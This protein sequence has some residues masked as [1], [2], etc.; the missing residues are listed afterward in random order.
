M[1]ERKI[2]WVAWLFAIVALTLGLSMAVWADDEWDF[3]TEYWFLRGYNGPGGD[4]VVPDQIEGCAVVSITH[5]VLCDS[6][7]ITSLKLPGT[8]E[9]LEEGTGSYNAEMTSVELPESLMVIGPNCFMQDPKL[10]EITIPAQVCVLETYSLSFDVSLSK[11]TFEGECPVMGPYVLY[12]LA[13]DCVIYVPDD[14]Y[15]AYMQEFEKYEVE[16]EVKP[17]GQNA[18]PRTPVYDDENL[19][20]DEDGTITEYNGYNT[21]L[22]IPE[23]LDGIKVKALGPEVFSFHYYL[24]YVSLPEG[25]E[26]IGESAFDNAFYL[27]YVKLPSSVRT[28]GDHAFWNSYHGSEIEWPESLET[29]GDEAFYASRLT[30]EL[31]LPEGV[32][33]IGEKAFQQTMWIS[34]A[35]L[36]STVEYIGA[37]AFYDSSIDY[38]S[39]ASEQLPDIDSTAFESCDSLRDIDINTHGTK[40]EMLALQADVDALGLECRVWRNQ[41]PDVEYAEGSKYTMN[42]DGSATAVMVEYTGDQANIRPYDSYTQDDATYYPVTG[43]A[44]Q[45]LK[46]NQ[47]VTYFAVCYNDQLTS[48]GAEAFADSVIEKVDLFDS[49]TTIGEGAFRNCTG[50]TELTLPASITNIGADA[51]EGCTNLEKVNIQCEMSALPEGAFSGLT[52]LKEVAIGKGDIPAR[53]FENTA[54]TSI[55]LSGAAVIGERAFAGCT[56]ITEVTLTDDVIAIGS[57]A[58]DGISVPSFIIPAGIAADTSTIPTVDI[59]NVRISDAATDD[60]VAAWN[61]VLAYPWYDGLCR[62][63][64]ESSFIHMPNEAT[65][66]ENFEIDPET[67]MLKTYKGTAVDVVIPTSISGVTVTGISYNCFES[68]R[69]YTDTGMDTNQTD[70]VHLR[71]IVIPETVTTIEDSVFNNC[72]Q[73]EVAIL[74]SPLETSGRGVFMNCTS[75]KQVVFVNP[76]KQLDNYLFDSCKSLESVWYRGTLDRIGE[77]CFN[78]SGIKEFIADAKWI[79]N[80]AFVHCPSLETL[81]VR[82]S[83][84]NLVMSCVG[85]CQNIKTICLEMTSTEGMDASNGSTGVMDTGTVL[86]IPAETSDEEAANFFRKWSNF[87]LGPIVSEENV[88]RE[89]CSVPDTPNMPDLD[90]LLR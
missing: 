67:G 79:D 88:H 14:Q 58:W 63:S 62:V 44:D 11:V 27:R 29:I 23:Q 87:N 39:I 57:G 86:I 26:A 84:E 53:C 64:E 42:P 69:D 12:A 48:I 90:G 2:T 22:D 3:D 56:G 52:N 18:V 47:T 21:R 4:V 37:G 70:W 65:A 55:D 60:A 19:V 5:N 13:D 31:H 80:S 40:E 9:S 73:L 78:H 81:H 20:I 51:F 66:E 82:A 50:L 6:E 32:R 10:K 76:I 38:V 28:I 36:P 83:C 8:L 25:L 24:G 46:G 74:Y 33:S 77:S 17:S 41:N 1:K 7:T 35:Y 89:T 45:A 34:A 54:I 68:C 49:V 43:I 15:D 61:E 72:Q 16:A 59:A 75:L 85:D 30:G 71:T